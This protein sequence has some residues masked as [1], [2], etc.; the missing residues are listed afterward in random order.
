MTSPYRKR[1]HSINEPGHAHFVT[2]SCWKRWP[3]LSKD[4]SR[5]W[6]I[7]SLNQSRKSLDIAIWAYVIM[8]DHV[9]LLILPRESGYEMRRILS[10]IKAPV[11]RSAKRYLQDTGDIEWL[12]RLTA[13]HGDRKTFR[14]WQPGGGYDSNLFKLKTIRETIDYIH[15]NP[16]RRG[17]VERPSDWKW[18][19]AAAHEGLSPTP[20]SIDQI[21]LD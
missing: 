18:S 13:G 10:G 14:S 11:S 5:Q 1:R 16:V 2:F 21:N 4:R 6:V 8:P 12:E 3:L 17:L 15:A 19:S 20:L 9:H 7:D